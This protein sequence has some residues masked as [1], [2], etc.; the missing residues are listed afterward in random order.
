M[1]QAKLLVEQDQLFLEEF[2][3]PE[4]EW[5]A[6]NREPFAS[7]PSTKTVVETDGQ[8]PQHNGVINAWGSAILRGEPLVADGREG[9]R[10]LMLS[11]AMH[12]SAFL[13]RAVELPVDELS[14][15]RRSN[16]VWPVPISGK[17][18]APPESRRI[19]A[20]MFA[21]IH[22]KTPANAGVFQA[23]IRMTTDL[24]LIS[25]F[26]SSSSSTSSPGA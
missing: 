16:N 21:G 13:D 6:V 15:L 26:P 14:V 24:G 5:S 18:T 17:M 9:I 1:D 12:L 3:M 19:S 20:G 10:G 23:V 8:N 4:P 2:S 22:G 25:T 11:N 7:M